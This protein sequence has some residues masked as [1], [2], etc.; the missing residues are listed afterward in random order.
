MKKF[1]QFIAE[2]TEQ[3]DAEYDRKKHEFMTT[4]KITKKKTRPSEKDDAEF[5]KRRHQAMKLK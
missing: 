3:E 4:G 1:K 5:D 2:K